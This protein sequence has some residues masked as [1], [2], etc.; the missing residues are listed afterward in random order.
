MRGSPGSWCTA[1]RGRLHPPPARRFAARRGCAGACDSALDR[2]VVESVD[3]PCI[4]LD[5]VAVP[6]GGERAAVSG[7]EGLQQVGRFAA[8]HLA[9]NDVIGAVP[10]GVA[11]EVADRDRC[12]SSGTRPGRAGRS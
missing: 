10:Q 7:V 4:G 11:H 12:S 6:H 5:V 2:H 9:D 3:V 8:A 1:S